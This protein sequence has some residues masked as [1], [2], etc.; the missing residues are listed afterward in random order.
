[1]S[2]R[3]PRSAKERRNISQGLADYWNAKGRKHATIAAGLGVTVLAGR[4]GLKK[5]VPVLKSKMR[6][7]LTKFDARMGEAIH[8]SVYQGVTGTGA[9]TKNP[10][11]D[12]VMNSQTVKGA[13]SGLR[14]GIR[15][16]VTQEKA[17]AAS[18]VKSRFHETVTTPQRT[19]E[20]FKIGR[21]VEPA[22]EVD[23]NVNRGKALARIYKRGRSD[24][25]KTFGFESGNAAFSFEPQDPERHPRLIE[26]A[27]RRKSPSKPSR[28]RRSRPLSEQHRQNISQGLQEYY[29]SLPKKEETLADKGEKVTKS[30]GRVAR[31]AKT[32][33]EAAD[34][35]SSV[36]EKF[37]KPEVRQGIGAGILGG[38][39]LVSGVA[40]SFKDVGSAARSV[41]GAVDIVHDLATGSKGKRQKFREDS[42][43]AKRDADKTN[44]QVHAVRA[45]LERKKAKLKDK[46]LN[47]RSSS[48]DYYGTLVNAA[49]KA[50]RLGGHKYEDART[51]R[52]KLER[53]QLKNLP[54]WD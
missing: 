44:R 29:D 51:R 35:A 41:A 21:N 52:A 12:A 53:D 4:Q 23:A 17:R 49:E 48:V 11:V 47:I 8:K 22:N 32:F 2:R 16:K 6:D 46:E 20:A 40:S 28:P 9:K 38:A 13:Q 14:E 26:F 25:K 39:A 45:M 1:M 19:V 7:Q 33:A 15:D 34:L 10:L 18:A 3:G 50:G 5:G 24:I 42:L 54:I 37:K 31:S 43:Q 27:K 30:I 36:Y